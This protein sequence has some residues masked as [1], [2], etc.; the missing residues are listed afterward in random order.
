MTAPY[1]KLP[2]QR[3]GFVHGSSTWMGADHI[4]VVNSMRFREEYKRF[5]L[6]DVQG[7]AVA[8]A[9][10][11]HISTRALGIAVLW[12]MALQTSKTL[13]PFGIHSLSPLLWAIAVL[14]VGAWV[15]V[16]AVCSCRCRIYTAVSR[17]DLPSVYRTWTARKFLAAVEPKIAEVQ[18]V[19]EGEWA[20]AAESRDIGP[21]LGALP[22]MPNLAPGPGESQSFA[23]AHTIVSDIFVAALFGSALF[24]FLTL[25]SSPQSVLWVSGG[26]LVV[27]IGLAAAIFVQHYKGKLA[28]G[29][30]KVAI[31]TLLAMGLLYYVD[32]MSA[33]FAAGMDAAKKQNPVAQ[34]TPVMV[35]GNRVAAEINGAVSLLLGCIGLGVIALAKESQAQ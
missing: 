28:G 27:K 23:P 32:Q 34:F 8:K 31:A 11:F 29:M 17:D 9:P 30:Q 35:S 19:L 16:S 24:T 15:Y 3:R 20:E 6:G 1:R 2:G 13:L 22:S 25:G 33:G 5:H 18:G 12:L 21:P 14:L 7:I 26:F 10:R 4:L